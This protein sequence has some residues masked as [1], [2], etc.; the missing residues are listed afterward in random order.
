M[1]TGRENVATA[2]YVT[3]E[4][5]PTTTDCMSETS[6]NN[7]SHHEEI[8]AREQG[9]ARQLSE[10]QL[11]MIAVGGAIGTGLFLGSAIAVRTAGPGVVLTYVF[12]AGITLLLM[13]CLAE[14]A[15]AHPTAGSFGI[16]AEIYLSRWAGFA[17]RYTYWA[18]QSIAIGGEAVA[19]GIYTQWWFPNTPVW[20]WV[21][22]YS[23]ALIVI[24][25]MSIGAFGTFEYWFAMIKVIAIL[26]FIVLGVAMIFGVHQE[27]PIGF[28]NFTNYG[29]FIPH[30]LMGVWLALA[31]VIYSF[32]GAEVVAVTAGE[33]KDPEKSVPRAMKTLLARLAIFYVGAIA[34]LVGVIP[35]TQVQPGHDITVSPF[36]RVFDVMHIPA[37]AHII[38]FVVLTA[39]LS[40]MNCNLY[41][42]TRMMFSLSR[43]G[44]APEMLGRVT[45]KGTPFAA[46]LCS[47][48]GL[49]AAVLLA[50]LFPGA[51]YVYMFGISLFGGLFAWL[52]IFITHLRFRR[53]WDARTDRTLPVRVKY[54][55]YTTILGGVAVLA[56]MVSTW[57]VDGMRVTLQAGL[58]WL[59]VITIA[60]YGVGKRRE[61]AA[62]ARVA[63]R[64]STSGSL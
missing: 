59:A 37:A 33:A 39:A 16:Y 9:L 57:W 22:V 14:M 54:F 62:R 30:G 43:A 18:A 26:V 56:V 29:G 60:Y 64:D 36:V 5:L 41:M 48:G 55:P 58:P 12:A 35:W 6:P 53:H 7:T 4:A 19:A 24:N 38:N 50:F 27:H 49:G 61:A 31:V 11:S 15:V 45:R 2:E 47:A 3:N 46:L 51:A 34:V 10:R 1:Y 17:I 23:V 28:A 21:V 40:S 44:Y 42:G 8:M 32:I 13:A 63:A 20:L 52:M 25:S